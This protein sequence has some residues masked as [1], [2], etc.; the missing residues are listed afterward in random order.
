MVVVMV[1]VMVC[2]SCADRKAPEPANNTPNVTIEGVVEQLAQGDSLQWTLTPPDSSWQVQSWTATYRQQ[3]V[4]T[5]Q[6]P[7]GS[8]P[9]DTL[10]MGIQSLQLHANLL[11]AT[12]DTIT[13]EGKVRFVVRANKPPQ[14]LTYRLIKRY[15]HPTNYYTQG[16]LYADGKLYEGTGEKGHSRLVVRE[17]ITGAIL[18]EHPLDSDY[19]GEGIAL[20]GDAL[21][22]L[23]WTSHEGFVYDAQTLALR[24][25]FRYPTEGWGMSTWQTPQD[26]LIVVSDGSSRLRY[27]Q[28]DTWT[29]QYSIDAYDHEGPVSNL[30]ELEIIEGLI[31]ANVYQSQHIVVIDPKYGV[32]VGKLA[33]ETLFDPVAYA[34]STKQRIDVLNGIAYDEQQGHL[35]IT[36]KLWPY[37]YRIETPKV[38]P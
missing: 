16:L 28:P 33:L 27:Y 36:G 11:E 14:E 25:Q 5:G 3:L 32:V 37:L 1:S 19:F 34:D 20:V 23:T 31:Y 21:Y 17:G 2:S 30:N 8:L 22:Q 9:T 13:W 29:L 24:R 6:T 10:P 4:A 38:L 12:G 18:A 35:L 15:P 26:T 7:I